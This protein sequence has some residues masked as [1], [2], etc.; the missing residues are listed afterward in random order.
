MTT[1][2]VTFTK[3]NCAFA[4]I[5]YMKKYGELIPN[6]EYSWKVKAESLQQFFFNIPIWVWYEAALKFEPKREG[7]WCVKSTPGHTVIV[8]DTVDGGL[9]ITK[10]IKKDGSI[11]EINNSDMINMFCDEGKMREYIS[12]QEDNMASS[13]H[14][15]D[16]FK[17]KLQEAPSLR[18]S[19][20]PTPVIPA[21][22][23]DT[24]QKIVSFSVGKRGEQVVT[25]NS[26]HILVGWTDDLFG[27]HGHESFSLISGK[28]TFKKPCTL[29]ITAADV[30][31]KGGISHV[32]QRIFRMK[33]MNEENTAKQLVLVEDRRSA[34]INRD[35]PTRQT[36]CH[37][38]TVAEGDV[39]YFE[40]EHNAPS[41]LSI[42]TTGTKICGFILL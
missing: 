13:R 5:E 24:A 29:V 4:L 17:D 38:T 42:A 2:T 36:I 7:Y 10:F 35:M 22:I 16:F 41:T 23:P 33:R 26:C 12:S 20:V 32:G 37:H 15:M 6:K 19:L 14:V 3:V 27:Y 28:F 25:A 1:F 34:D 11:R 18:Q 30:A 40:V 9:M 31:W 8:R 21:L 39:V